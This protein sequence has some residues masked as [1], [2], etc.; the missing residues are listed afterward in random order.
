MR[1][2]LESSPNHTSFKYRRLIKKCN[3]MTSTYLTFIF[4]ETNSLEFR[5]QH[6]SRRDEYLCEHFVVSITHFWLLSWIG[7]S[8]TQLPIA[9]SH[10]NREIHIRPTLGNH[11]NNLTWP[12]KFT[13]PN[14]TLCQNNEGNTWPY[15]LSLR[16][17]KFL[18][19]LRIARH[20]AAIQQLSQPT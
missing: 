15:L 16:S 20:N 17:H 19:G 9:Q 11:H 5:L 18:K 7:K 2:V 8:L 12:Q 4:K 10:P 14:C 13:N 3:R 1:F 6:L